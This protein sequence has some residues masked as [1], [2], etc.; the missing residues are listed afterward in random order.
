VKAYH[1]LKDDMRSG[2][3]TEPPWTVGEERTYE[4]DRIALCKSGYHSSPSWRAALNYAP[5]TVACL[6][7][8]SKPEQKDKSKQVSQT[9][10]LVAAMNVE[11]EMRLFACDCA[12]RALKQERKAGREP[13]ER[14]WQAIA[15]SRLFA[16]GKASRDQ[17]IIAATAAYAATAIYVAMAGY[18]AT[19]AFAAAAAAPALTASAPAYN[20]TQKREIAWQ[21]RRLAWYLNRAFRQAPPL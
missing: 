18:A 3:G 9:R 1:F 4:G 11:R 15:V 17:L 6:V 20:V 12:E 2:K 14:S 21:K 5:G 19:A 10:R 13:D 7:E 8:I 16:Q